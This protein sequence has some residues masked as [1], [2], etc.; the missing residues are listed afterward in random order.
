[1]GVFK[2]KFCLYWIKIYFLSFLFHQALQIQT[3]LQSIWASHCAFNVLVSIAD[4]EYMSA[5]SVESN[6][7]PLSLKFSKL[8]PKLAMMYQKEFT[9]QMSTRLLL[10]ERLRTVL[11]VRKFLKEMLVSSIFQKSDEKNLPI[12]AIASKKYSN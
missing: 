5:K 4:S 9:R 12:T 2:T 8:W 6:Q 7:I 10:P 1:M 3:G 11:K